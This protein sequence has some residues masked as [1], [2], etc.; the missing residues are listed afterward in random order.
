MRSLLSPLP[1]GARNPYAEALRGAV[2]AGSVV[3]MGQSAGTVLVGHAVGPVTADAAN[4][5]LEERPGTLVHLDLRGILGDRWL[6]PGF[7]A[8][9]GLGCKMVL[10]PHLTY[11]PG[12][13][14]W[15]LQSYYS[16]NVALLGDAAAAVAAADRGDR[17]AGAVFG[18]PL[19][20]F[21]DVSEVLQVFRGEVALHVPSM[22]GLSAF[23]ARGVPREGLVVPWNCTESLAA[24]WRILRWT[25]DG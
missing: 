22:S 20:D 17:G 2:R 10:R 24:D 1:S 12:V 16:S 18:V 9:V 19:M 25:L 7:D 14:G 21:G 5:T 6:F 4:V 3:Y 23:A 8:D 11:H 13:W 15:H